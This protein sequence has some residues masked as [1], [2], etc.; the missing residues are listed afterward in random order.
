VAGRFA[1]GTPI[2]QQQKSLMLQLGI[3]R[4][5]EVIG[6]EALE[7]YLSYFKKPM[8]EE[9]LTACLALFGWLPSALPIVVEEDLVV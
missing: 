9:D 4:A 3:A 8:S 5:G 7:A 2:K 6:D 1:A